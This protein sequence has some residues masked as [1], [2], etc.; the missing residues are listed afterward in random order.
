MR[1][2]LMWLVLLSVS[3]SAQ[4]LTEQAGYWFGTFASLIFRLGGSL[5]DINADPVKFVIAIKIGLLVLGS[6]I[7]YSSRFPKPLK[8]AALAL[9][10]FTLV[11]VRAEFLLTAT[12][13][14]RML[15][16]SA[17]LVLVGFGLMRGF[18]L[19]YGRS[20]WV[21]LPVLFGLIFVLWQVYSVWESELSG[22][23][24]FGFQGI[25]ILGAMGLG[26][27][28]LFAVSKFLP[29]PLALK[30]A[31]A[32]RLLSGLAKLSKLKNELKRYI[33]KSLSGAEEKIVATAE[34][35][36]RD[37]EL[38][39]KE[40]E[41]V[42]EEM[43][44]Y[45]EEV[46]ARKAQLDA[47]F[48]SEPSKA[49]E[50]LVANHVSLATTDKLG[51]ISSIDDFIQKTVSLR[52]A[53]AQEL[54]RVESFEDSKKVAI[55]A[56]AR[57]LS[58]FAR[59]LAILDA[60]AKVC[61]KLKEQVVSLPLSDQERAAM[62]GSLVGVEREVSA[63]KAQLE[64]SKGKVEQS[65]KDLE[66]AKSENKKLKTAFDAVS[67]VSLESF[68]G[69][70]HQAWESAV[71]ADHDISSSIPNLQAGIGEVSAFIASVRDFQRIVGETMAYLDNK[72]RDMVSACIDPS[73]PQITLLFSRIRT[74]L[75]QIVARCDAVQKY[76]DLRKKEALF[77]GI[78]SKSE[79]RI[80]GSLSA[81]KR[82]AQTVFSSNAQLWS[83]N[84][85]A[86]GQE[87]ALGG[88][89]SFFDMALRQ[90]GLVQSETKRI[91]DFL[92]KLVAI[93][94]SLK[95]DF[96]KEQA[97]LERVNERERRLTERLAQIIYG[98]EEAKKQ[99]AILKTFV[100]QLSSADDAK[101]KAA[102]DFLESAHGKQV[103]NHVKASLYGVSNIA[104]QPF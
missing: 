55:D 4:S 50:Y 15:I 48:S 8:H 3:V 67:K 18:K 26:I 52:A 86:A 10:L 44:K 23:I 80:S 6:I 90:I 45:E 20:K 79:D 58:D 53:L 99:A 104:S 76:A 81:I 74:P 11:S 19:V 100:V 33:K 41:R 82:S 32:E 75:T 9:L 39:R 101:R 27:L 91:R 30:A 103:L 93:K 84:V 47:V 49:L 31:S 37:A 12:G 7:I 89:I 70:L 78:V 34:E 98:N 64:Q 87:A 69:V 71:G 94:Q 40:M 56:V 1:K 42:A 83:G 21:Q 22:V 54:Q 65:L 96:S 97:N 28:L 66:V 14:L 95:E 68:R 51:I 63:Y 72:L 73:L 92:Q 36:A 35:L 77:A 2:G 43:R 17:F 60:Q 62:L 25:L 24:S 102:Q 16:Q 88:L 5:E 57:L 61:V 46:Q 85:G 59:E 29:E 38:R 13:I